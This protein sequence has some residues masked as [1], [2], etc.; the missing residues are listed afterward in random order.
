VEVTECEGGTYADTTGNSACFSCGVYNPEGI[1]RPFYHN[2]DTGRVDCDPC[3][4]NGKRGT[5]SCEPATGICQCRGLFIGTADGTNVGFEVDCADEQDISKSIALA[6]TFFA[7]FLV[8]CVPLL[9][10]S[11]I[12]A[13]MSFSFRR[14]IAILASRMRLRTET[15]IKILG[16][17]KRSEDQRKLNEDL[18]A[19]FHA[20][21][22]DSGGTIDR[23]ELGA[24]VRV[25]QIHPTEEEMAAS[26][27][28]VDENNDGELDFNEF[29][30]LISVLAQCEARRRVRALR[31]SAF[32]HVCARLIDA[33]RTKDLCQQ[34]VPGLTD[35]DVAG[36]V[37]AHINFEG[38][39]RQQAPRL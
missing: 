3:A 4:C 26:I 23:E 15:A 12:L 39:V 11:G 27:R 14:D 34:L 30:H 7:L 5:K 19:R 8:V 29:R 21:D 37:G 9:F 24:F 32:R 16:R 35:D 36:D 22:E 17:Q 18:E 2:L 13:S 6:Y 20:L 28:I 31:L 25:V 1:N 33:G 38:E 10:H